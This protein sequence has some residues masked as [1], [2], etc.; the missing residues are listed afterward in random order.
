[1]LVV[2]EVQSL[3]VVVVLQSPIKFF[4]LIALRVKRRV[5]SGPA[6][7]NEMPV[8]NRLMIMISC[9]QIA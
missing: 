7:G 2:G 8:V 9:V 4:S 5:Q 6:V 3:G 1:V